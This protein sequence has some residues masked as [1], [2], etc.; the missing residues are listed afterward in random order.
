M[1]L[2]NKT[3]QQELDYSKSYGLQYHNRNWT[4]SINFTAEYETVKVVKGQM[5]CFFSL[6]AFKDPL[7]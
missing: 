2:S 1:S 5:Q 3:I 6:F 7:K 4:S